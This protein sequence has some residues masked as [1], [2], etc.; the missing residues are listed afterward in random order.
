MIKVY[1]DNVWNDIY[2][3]DII[4]NFTIF[5][6]SYETE[7]HFN[8]YIL[9]KDGNY[10]TFIIQDEIKLPIADWFDVKVFL[11]DI[12]NPQWVN[13][14][15]YQTW[16]FYDFIYSN[17]I[18]ESYASKNSYVFDHVE[19][20]YNNIYPNIIFKIL[21][22]ENGSISYEK[23]DEHKT[24]IRINNNPNERSYYQGFYNRI[25]SDIF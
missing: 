6:H 16:A 18:E 8:N 24:R 7:M 11:C 25:T 20:P 23:N 3:I 19:I 10:K 15:D 4:N 22:N 17:K 13:G 14:R 21:Y 5:R 9:V 2:D 1:K 12:M